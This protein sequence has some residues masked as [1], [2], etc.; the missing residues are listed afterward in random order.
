M[1]GLFALALLLGGCDRLF[2]LSRLTYDD[3]VDAALDAPTDALCLG[4][5]M[6]TEMCITLPAPILAIGSPIDTNSDTRCRVHS[7]AKGPDLCV[8]EGDVILVGEPVQVTGDRPLVLLAATTIEIAAPLDASSKLG[9]RTGAG[10]QASCAGGAGSNGPAGAGGGAGGTFGFPGGTGGAGLSGTASPTSGGVPSPVLPLTGVYG[11]CAGGKGGEATNEDAEG[12]PGGGAIYVIAGEQIEV[13]MI[14]S[15]NASGAGGAGGGLGGGGGGGGGAG[16]F[17]ALDAPKLVID[18]PVFARGGGGGGGGDLTAAGG[19]GADPAAAGGQTPGG[20]SPENGAPGGDGCG[21]PEGA[22]GG[23]AA[24]GKAGGGGG[25][26]SCGRIQFWG[27]RSG[28]G[29]VNPAPT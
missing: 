24:A 12:G 19:R 23:I 16:G 21:A 20:S 13:A 26:G 1:R 6:L 27:T 10:A 5:G 17:I 3:T 18:G 14:A 11:G 22:Q 9:V 15:I 2:G 25:G 8:I 29:V 7:Q 28:A 4:T